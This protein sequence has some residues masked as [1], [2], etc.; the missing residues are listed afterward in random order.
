MTWFSKTSKTYSGET[1]LSQGSDGS[2][3]YLKSREIRFVVASHNSGTAVSFK[4]FITKYSIEIS[5]KEINETKD[6]LNLDREKIFTSDS[7]GIIASFSL[8]ILAHSLNEAKVNIKRI[9]EL[10]RIY[11]S[12]ISQTP[13]GSDFL[14]KNVLYVSAMNIFTA[15]YTSKQEVTKDNIKQIG[16][17]CFMEEF[18][19]TV[20]KEMGMFE[21]EGT[22]LPKKFTLEL[23]FKVS[24]SAYFVNNKSYLWLPLDPETREDYLPSDVGTFPFG[25]ESPAGNRG[26]DGSAIYSATRDSLIHIGGISNLYYTNFKPFLNSLDSKYAYIGM[27]VK[28]IPDSGG[29]LQ[30]DGGSEHIKITNN[31]N[32]SVINH[33]L[34]EAKTNMLKLQKLIRFSDQYYPEQF[35]STGAAIF[36]T[37]KQFPTTM[38]LK[39]SS[40]LSYNNDP[41]TDL[42][43]L[44]Q[45]GKLYYIKGLSFEFDLTMGMFEDNGILYFKKYDI[46]FNLDQ[47]MD[48]NVFQNVTPYVL[49]GSSG[50]SSLKEPEP[51][52]DLSFNSIGI[53]IFKD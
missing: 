13:A 12:V 45:A 29:A 52:G 30:F 21:D 10:D 4:P 1:S 26:E 15:A 6:Y 42:D 16:V 37:N 24:N 17:P 38:F 51:S 39:F 7:I 3:E 40:L 25:I 20:D 19:Y 34:N 48:G 9:N 43:S 33:S 35:D 47:Y 31:L 11:K 46:S 18:S 5:N 44:K 14:V 28:E 53:Q 36:P 27:K 50:E 8:D 41:V 32:F 22:L 49:D 23:K 2:S